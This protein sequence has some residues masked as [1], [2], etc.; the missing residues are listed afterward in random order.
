VLK[1]A[2]AFAA[3]GPAQWTVSV[4]LLR[5]VREQEG[6]RWVPSSLPAVVVVVVVVAVVGCHQEVVGA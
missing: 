2:A 4:E 6:E 5:M 1:K 3:V